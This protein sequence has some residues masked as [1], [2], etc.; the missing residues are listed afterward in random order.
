[1]QLRI[2]QRRDKENYETSL[3]VVFISPAPLNH[4]LLIACSKSYFARVAEKSVFAMK[5]NFTYF[6]LL[7]LSAH[8]ARIINF[9]HPH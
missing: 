3:L 5:I 4:P 8:Q 7:S 9:F 1:M 6:S 2:D